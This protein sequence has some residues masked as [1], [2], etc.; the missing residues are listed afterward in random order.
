MVEGTAVRRP[1]ATVRVRILTAMLLVAAAGLAVTGTITYLV[2]HDRV[3]RDVDAE[4]ARQVETARGVVEGADAVDAREALVAVFAVVLPP[5]D[6]SAVG[7]LDGEAALVPG[8]EVAFPLTGTGLVERVVA[9]VADGSARLGTALLDDRQVRYLGIPVTV[10]EDRGIYLV[11]IDVGLRLAPTER[12]LLVFVVVAGATL[13]AVG[14]AGWLVAG[15]L[16]RPIRRLRETAERITATDLEERIPVEGSD[17]VSRLT[18]TVNGMLDRLDDALRSQREL[19]DD[20]RHE[21]RTPLTVVRGHL[22]LLDPADAD[23]VRHAREIAVDELDRMAE[24]VSGLAALAETRGAILDRDEV[25]VGELTRDVADRAR[26]L[27]DRP[28]TVAAAADGVAVLDRRRIVQAWLQ[29]VENAVRYAPAGTPIELG[30]AAVPGG[31]E[32]WVRDEGPGV[33]PDQRER[34]FDRFARAPGTAARGSGLGLAIVDGILRAH[35]GSARVEPAGAGSR[36]I[37]SVPQGVGS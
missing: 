36:F 24:L 29:L 12:S 3:L 9:E 19:L 18:A 2:Q 10:G 32:F 20:V 37:L 35:G 8:T 33:P 13:L 4:L 31:Y 26:A 34:I 5:P 14:I 16:L 28:W 11:A 23:D 6:G 1:H 25:D 22:E 27:A 7:I 17:D 21:L 15:R 30:S